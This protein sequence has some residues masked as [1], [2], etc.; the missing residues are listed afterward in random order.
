MLPAFF[1]NPR[2]TLRNLGTSLKAGLH[3]EEG[4]RILDAILG[5]AL[6]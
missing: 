4:V 1:M 3:E 6:L 5:D 2:R